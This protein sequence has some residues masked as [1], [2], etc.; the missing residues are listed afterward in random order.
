VSVAAF[1][2]LIVILI[3]ATI[4]MVQ[5]I[6]LSFALNDLRT[7]VKKVELMCDSNGT[8]VIS[9][10]VELSKVVDSLAGSIAQQ[11]EMRN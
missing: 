4:S 9:A 10:L 8:S 6:L 7:R 1:I 2:I 3:I 11:T 5:H